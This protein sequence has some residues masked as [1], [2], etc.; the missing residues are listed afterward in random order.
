MKVKKYV[1][2]IKKN[3][4]ILFNKKSKLEKEEEKTL[5]FRLSI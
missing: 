2:N 4:K 5:F 1:L 3:M